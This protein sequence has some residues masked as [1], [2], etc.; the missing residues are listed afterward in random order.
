MHTAACR[1]STSG[2]GKP[3]AGGM[4]ACATLRSAALLALLRRDGPTTHWRSLRA[5]SMGW[6]AMSEPGVSR[7]GESWRVEWRRGGSSF[8][9]FASYGGTT[10]GH[11]PPPNSLMCSCC[12]PGLAKPSRRSL[13]RRVNIAGGKRR[14]MAER[15][16]FE[17]PCRLRDKTLSRRPRYDHFGTSPTGTT[18]GFKTCVGPRNGPANGS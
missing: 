11:P 6:P 7:A 16:G 10:R 8:A 2:C 4:S 12:R 18:Y 1:C 15:G 3:K 14:R 9:R 5:F 17:P 13:P